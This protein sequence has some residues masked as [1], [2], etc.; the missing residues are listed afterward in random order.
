LIA[1]A[2][3]GNIFV[4]M[5]ALGY[6]EPYIDW[7]VMTADYIGDSFTLSVDGAPVIT[8]TLSSFKGYPTAATRPD[9]LYLGSLALL[10]TPVPWTD[11]EVDWLRVYAHNSVPLPRPGMLKATFEAAPAPT[12]PPRPIRR[13]C[14]QD[15]SPTP[16]TGV[17]SSPELRCRPTGQG[18]GPGSRP[19]MTALA[20][21]WVSLL[22]DHHATGT[23]V[24]AVFDDMLHPRSF[25][26][27][28]SP[29]TRRRST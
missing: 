25:R 14:R 24:W 2:D 5:R 19:F 27:L 17:R 11:I 6:A 18:E 21:G 28:P 29:S 13:S 22:T 12:A 1:G 7:V 20:G 15:R 9:A 4:D 16:L 10:E 8:R 26:H 23:P 3:R